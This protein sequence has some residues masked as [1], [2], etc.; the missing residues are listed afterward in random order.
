VEGVASITE[1]T[2]DRTPRLDTLDFHAPGDRTGEAK[3]V[4]LA[5]HLCRG[6]LGRSGLRLRPKPVPR[7]HRRRLQAEF[8]GLDEDARA[9][10]RSLPTL[11]AYEA[12]VNAPARVGWLRTIHLR[13]NDV[14]VTFRFDPEVEPIPPERIEAMAWDLEIAGWELNRTHWAVK[15]AELLRV[16]RGDSSAATDPADPPYASKNSAAAAKV[17]ALA[18]LAQERDVETVARAVRDAIEKNEPA[19]GLDRLHTFTTALLRAICEAHGISA[20]RE[21]P[22]HSIFGEY[23]KHLRTAG[24]IE[25]EMTERILKS[26]ISILDAFNDVRNNR[27]LAHVNEILNHDEALLIFLHVVEVLRFVQQIERRAQQT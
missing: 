20:P 27:S 10:L 2:R 26:S 17:A 9:K 21:K 11:F 4:Q 19:S 3:R 16:I 13:G 18:R 5:D 22:L 6:S 14:R 15:K 8:K 23:V 12:P 1:Y 24:H 7:V 25:S